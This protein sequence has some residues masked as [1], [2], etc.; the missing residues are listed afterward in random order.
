M[1]QQI[2]LHKMAFLF[3]LILLTVFTVV[4]CGSGAKDQ[5]TVKPV[6]TADE[7]M[8]APGDNE[9]ATDSEPEPEFPYIAP[10]TGKGSTQPMD[11]RIIMVMVN[12][13]SKARP[14][15]GLDKADIVY[16]VLSEGAITRMLALYHSQ[17]PDVIGPVRSIRPYFIDIG[18]GYDAVMV[19][20]G[21]SPDALKQLRN[22]GLAHLDE[23]YNGGA[24]FWR[25]SFRKPPHN[26]YTNLQKIRQGAEDLGFRKISEIPHLLFVP[27]DQ[28]AVGGIA[29][30]IN[31]AYTSEY[32]V[33]YQYDQESK[34]YLRSTEGKLHNDLTTGNQLTATNVLVAA[35]PHRILDKEGRRAVDVFGPGEGYLFQ[36]GKVQKVTW[37]RRD[38]VIRAFVDNKEVG[39]YPGNTWVHIIPHVPP[40]QNSV[41]F[42]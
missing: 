35:A 32:A 39:L 37:E 41:T 33:S 23:I 17:E 22:E 15:S 25:E 19:H 31:I 20:A 28:E 16:E 24:Y 9:E 26:L 5:E 29:T 12:N 7:E 11:H 2:T 1:K 18:L 13:L 34:Q 40:L 8:P 14:Q 6:E 21:G 38:G 10:L 3:L 27:E 36:R 4:A 42:N 30:N